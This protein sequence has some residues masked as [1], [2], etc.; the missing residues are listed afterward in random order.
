MILDTLVKVQNRNRG[1]LVTV[2]MLLR[3]VKAKFVL[4]AE[5]GNFSNQIFHYTY[6][7]TRLFAE[8][9]N[10]FA[11]PTYASLR[12][13]NTDSFKEM[14][15]RWRAISNTMSDL[16][17]PRLKSQTSFSKDKRVTLLLTAP[18]M[19]LSCFCFTANHAYSKLLF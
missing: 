3:Y 19:G 12:P 5:N 2:K 7:I 8:A 13:N 4:F 9:H 16:S 18:R 6:C 11:G 1:I 15:L 17:G 10:K 14:S